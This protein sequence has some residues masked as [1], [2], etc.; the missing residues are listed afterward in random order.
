MV[1]AWTQAGKAGGSSGEEVCVLLMGSAVAPAGELAL[2]IAN[3]GLKLSILAG[4][5][6]EYDAPVD[7]GDTARQ[8][9]VKNR[10]IR[11]S[12]RAGG[13]RKDHPARRGTPQ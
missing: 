5:I 6:I 11:L 8:Q 12:V 1:E 2:A 4:L 13:A 9:R 10:R 3:H 7:R